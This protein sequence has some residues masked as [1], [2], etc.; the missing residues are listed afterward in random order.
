M[1]QTHPSAPRTAATGPVTVAELLARHASARAGAPARRTSAD[2]RGTSGGNDRIR[3]GGT[4]RRVDPAPVEDIESVVQSTYL[5]SLA[6]AVREELLG[7]AGLVHLRP[8]EVLERSK[9]E[10][11]V[12]L[13][14]SGVAHVYVERPVGPPHTLNYARKGSFISFAG[15]LDGSEPENV[16]AVGNVVLLQFDVDDF[17][18]A[19]ESSAGASS[20]LAQ[21][22]AVLGGEAVHQPVN[23]S[24][25]P[26]WGFQPGI[27]QH[28]EQVLLP[29]ATRSLV[30][31]TTIAAGTLVVAGSVFG[32]VV[33]N[34]AAP[35]GAEAQTLA[36]AEALDGSGG[37][38]DHGGQV[39][40]ALPLPV[41]LDPE[42]AAPTSW[43]PVAFPDA[44]ENRPSAEGVRPAPGAE[45][46]RPPAAAGA[47]DPVAGEDP[48]PVAADLPD[49]TED[50]GG[51]EAAPPITDP[52]A[53]VLTPLPADSAE[54]FT[55]PQDRAGGL[56]DASTGLT[57]LASEAPEPGVDVV[58]PV[59]GLAGLAPG[60]SVEGLVPVPGVAVDVDDPVPGL[61][62]WA[63]ET[64]VEASAPVPGVALD[65]VHSISGLAGLAE[66]TAVEPPAPPPAPVAEVPGDLAG[67]PSG[68]APSVAF[69][70]PAMSILNAQ[71]F[72]V[73]VADGW[74][75]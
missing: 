14:V 67:Y 35:A 7:C 57:G 39:N 42:L 6:K 72:D 18:E 15:I 23:P 68:S 30:H 45:A 20:A 19:C 66:G 21:E 16:A 13:V 40:A 49:L 3:P 69:A 70:D 61:T 48:P 25:L 71:P 29:G 27:R 4:A 64:P 58:D 56:D 59:P 44:V 24:D 31:H 17:L 11:F 22:I 41:A 65:A 37:V 74:V 33:L 50:L 60:A 38:L 10:P 47:T 9:L 63:P 51:A 26:G 73:S 2:N 62:S 28:V 8:G 54:V 53:E 55:A 32:V 12:A 52:P 36:G 43:L 34:D 5:G 75:Y 46:G 1:T